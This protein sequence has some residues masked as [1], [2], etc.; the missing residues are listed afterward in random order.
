M[1]DAFQFFGSLPSKTRLFL[2]GAAWVALFHFLGNSTFGYSDTPSLFSWLRAVYAANPDD[3]IGYLIPPLILFL[4]Y[5]RRDELMPLEKRPW[6]PALPLLAL[7]LL[8]HA[9]GYLVQQARLSVVACGVGIY[10]LTGLMW[11]PGWLRKTAF[12]FALLIFVVPITAYSTG[13]TFPLRLLSTKLAVG[14]C[15]TLLNLDLIRQGTTVFHAL[16]DGRM[17]FEFD[18][19]PACSGIRSLTVV[20]LLTLVYGYL[21]F[22]SWWRRAA[23]L[24]AAI[25]L[26]VLA[27]VIRLSIVFTVGEAW[28]GEAGK[29]I[30][31]NLGFITF[32][33]GLGGVLLLGRWL[34]ERP[35]A[36]GAGP[37][38]PPPGSPSTALPVP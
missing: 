2:V 33:V 12:P 28:G 31:T 29:R 13:L 21:Q 30:E 23:L 25:P 16:P 15:T 10:A 9:T 19:A 17:G 11:G 36:A 27:N 38:E 7:A 6:A 18:V 32:L 14:L 35:A 22:T 4:L 1:N 34:R 20:F 24:V 37:A 3:A 5:L 8:I 26:A